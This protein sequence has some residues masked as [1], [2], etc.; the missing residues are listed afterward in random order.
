MVWIYPNNVKYALYVFLEYHMI[1]F[2]HQVIIFY[3][4]HNCS[5]PNVLI[6]VYNHICL[7]YNNY[8]L[9]IAGQFGHLHRVIITVTI[10]IVVIC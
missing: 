9:I 6:C 4:L 2:Y 10:A 7:F 3:I 1:L 8:I 5:I